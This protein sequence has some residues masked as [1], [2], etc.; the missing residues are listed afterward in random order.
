MFYIIPTKRGLGVELWGTF[1]DLKNIYD[2]VGKFWNNDNKLPDKG[3]AS[4]DKLLSAVSYDLRKA[5]EGRRLKRDKSHFSLD[6][7]TYFGC[8]ISWVHFIFSLHALRY[9][10]RFYETN[11]FDIAT[12]L[13]L[14]FWLEKSITTFDGPGAAKLIA[15]ID[16]GIHAGNNN[17]YLFMRSINIDYFQLGGGKRNFRKL[18]NL[19]KRGVLY[20]DEYKSYTAFLEIEAKKLKRNVID[21]ELNDEHVDYEIEW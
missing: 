12:M 13:Q 3:F 16:S 17:I 8:K 14:E 6:E 10:M 7:I 1:D 19:L 2:V 5:H 21:L 18:P 4:R 11:K 20:S 9:N 15:F